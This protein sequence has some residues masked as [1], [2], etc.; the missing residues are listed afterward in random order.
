LGGERGGQQG[1]GKAELRRGEKRYLGA[2]GGKGG[3]PADTLKRLRVG[4]LEGSVGIDRIE[5]KGGKRRKW[6]KSQENSLLGEKKKTA[7]FPRG[8]KVRTKRS[9]AEGEREHLF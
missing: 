4:P 5:E 3:V 8:E 2:L 6:K 9:C 7:N 1:G